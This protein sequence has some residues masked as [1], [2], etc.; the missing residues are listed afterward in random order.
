MAEEDF[1][2]VPRIRQVLLALDFYY[3]LL[4]LIVS[5]KL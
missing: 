2:L 4:N 5:C 3:W 1:W